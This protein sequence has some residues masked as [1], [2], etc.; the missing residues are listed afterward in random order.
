MGRRYVVPIVV[1]LVVVVAAGWLDPKK[2]SAGADKQIREISS[3]KEIVPFLNGDT[4]LVFDVDNTVLEPAAGN[5]GSDQWWYYLARKY[6]AIDGLTEKEADKKAM[7]LWNKVQWLIEVRAV[8]RITPDIM[9]EQQKLGR[10]VMGFTA[11]TPSI[12]AITLE[13]LKSI[14]VEYAKYPIHSKEF[15]FKL[16]G[17]T[18]LYTKGMLFI[19]EGNDK[20]TALVQFLE[21]IKLTPKRIVF[22]D[23]KVKNVESV[24]KALAKQRLEFLCFRYAVTDAK[25]K[26]FEADTRDIQL[27]FGGELSNEAKAALK[28]AGK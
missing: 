20:G 11:R 15:E 21:E 1:L 4:L 14:G 24:A 13:Q 5:L 26:Q 8:E 19:G 9:R 3:M 7:D 25:V 10:K 6:T 27:F 16:A 23:D 17:D 12:A 28:K 2:G 22:V 18:A